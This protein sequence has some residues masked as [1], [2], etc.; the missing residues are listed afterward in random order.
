MASGSV[1]GAFCGVDASLKEV[2][3]DLPE[4][5]VDAAEYFGLLVDDFSALADDSDDLLEY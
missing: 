1:W 5:D 4:P 3:S 2:F